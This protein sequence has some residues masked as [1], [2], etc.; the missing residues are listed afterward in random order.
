M[1]GFL[2]S[3]FRA[4]GLTSAGV[5]ALVAVLILIVI[6]AAALCSPWEFDLPDLIMA[7]T[8]L[9]IGVV[10][11]VWDSQRKRKDENS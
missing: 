9:I 3:F 2:S 7:A 11:V 4:L 10:I 1:R 8:V 5:L 6:L